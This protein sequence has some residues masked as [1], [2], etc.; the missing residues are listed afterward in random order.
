MSSPPYGWMTDG[1]YWSP[2]SPV[3]QTPGVGQTLK[4]TPIQQEVITTGEFRFVVAWMPE[5]E[6]GSTG[7]FYA[8]FEHVQDGAISFTIP[9][10]TV[11][12]VIAILDG[13]GVPVFSPTNVQGVVI[14][15]VTP[16]Q[17]AQGSFY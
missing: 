14:G 11:L 10:N 5:I 2:N 4:D 17:G 1:T 3:N 7:R 12:P 8:Y 13:N 6:A 16:N 9:P 15:T